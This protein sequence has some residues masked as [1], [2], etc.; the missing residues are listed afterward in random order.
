MEI[1]LLSQAFIYPTLNTNILVRQ[2]FCLFPSFRI[3][4]RKKLT[5]T[6]TPYYISSIT[7]YNSKN[8]GINLYSLN[9]Y[10]QIFVYSIVS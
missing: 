9:S 8:K 6:L 5:N 4:P 3:N 7:Y 10:A 2:L 1:Y